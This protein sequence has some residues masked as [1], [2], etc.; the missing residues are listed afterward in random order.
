MGAQA[1]KTHPMQVCLLIISLNT[2]AMGFQCYGTRDE[3]CHWC[4][5]TEWTGDRVWLMFW[6]I[7]DTGHVRGDREAMIF[8]PATSGK[9]SRSSMSALVGDLNS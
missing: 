6:T 8:R 5:L 1:P 7:P 3:F 4:I 9:S 2:L